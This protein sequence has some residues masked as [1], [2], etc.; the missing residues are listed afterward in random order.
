MEAFL[1]E[2][3]ERALELA[4]LATSFQGAAEKVPTSKAPITPVTRQPTKR[5]RP[6]NDVG[7]IVDLD[8][9]DLLDGTPG[10]RASQRRKSRGSAV[11]SGRRVDADGNAFADAFPIN[12]APANKCV[13]FGTAILVAAVMLDGPLQR[14]DKEHKARHLHVIKSAIH[15]AFDD[16]GVIEFEILEKDP[17]VTRSETRALIASFCIAR[18]ESSRVIMLATVARCKAWINANLFGP[19]GPHPAAAGMLLGFY[20]IIC[21]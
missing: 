8:D 16:D 14:E 7:K 2:N 6:D 3:P 17:D 21:N 20:V 5:P 1:K 10:D 11:K 15:N 4:K 19:G 9:T 18:V 13:P 12:R